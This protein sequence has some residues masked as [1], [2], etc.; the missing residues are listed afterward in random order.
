MIKPSDGVSSVP[1]PPAA[2]PRAPVPAPPE[3]AGAYA[4]NS[5]WGTLHL[6]LHADELHHS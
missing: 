2:R 4:S 3:L 1:Q 5:M 6:A